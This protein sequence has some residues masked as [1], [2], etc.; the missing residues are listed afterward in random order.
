VRPA[1]SRR[2]RRRPRRTRW[3][4]GGIRHGARR[5]CD[6]VAVQLASQ[7]PEEGRG[8]VNGDDRARP[9]SCQHGE[10]AGAAAEVGNVGAVEEELVDDAGVELLADD[11]VVDG[12]VWEIAHN[13]GWVIVA[14][15]AVTLV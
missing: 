7:P 12:Y 1:R 2:L 3:G 14:D 10:S 9:R 6:A 8:G 15:G 11:E 4:G 13:P 5:H